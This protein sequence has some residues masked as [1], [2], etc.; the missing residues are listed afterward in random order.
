M[1]DVF[2]TEIGSGLIAYP[3]KKE[4]RSLLLRI[5]TVCF[6]CVLVPC[7]C[8]VRFYCVFYTVCLPI[9]TRDKIAD[10]DIL[11]AF[12]VFGQKLGLVSWL[13]H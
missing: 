5:F 8:T 4:T 1:V 6:H 2:E 7:V 13:T 12:V 10:F 11:V 9:E 3:S